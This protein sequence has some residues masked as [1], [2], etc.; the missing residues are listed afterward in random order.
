M[1]ANKAILV[2]TFLDGDKKLS[3]KTQKKHGQCVMDKK[4]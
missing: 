3:L 4:C 2:S 1:E